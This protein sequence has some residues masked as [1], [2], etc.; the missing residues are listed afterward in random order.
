M[1]LSTESEVC[2]TLG[3]GVDVRLMLSGATSDY[4]IE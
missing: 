2:E 3:N 4:F 1:G